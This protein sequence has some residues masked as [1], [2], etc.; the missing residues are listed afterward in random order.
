MAPTWKAGSQPRKPRSSSASEDSDSSA[1]ASSRP[2][3]TSAKR[4]RLAEVARAKPGPAI[5][6]LHPQ[7]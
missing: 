1:S 2:V 6:N 3:Q 4:R 7:D 5:Q